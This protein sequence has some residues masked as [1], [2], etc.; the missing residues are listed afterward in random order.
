[1]KLVAETVEFAA[2]DADFRKVEAYSRFAIQMILGHVVE[3]VPVLFLD[4]DEADSKGVDSA[5]GIG[6]KY[7]PLDGEIR[8]PMEA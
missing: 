8:Q 5:F 7:F 2:C 3:L 4:V 1:M 6:P